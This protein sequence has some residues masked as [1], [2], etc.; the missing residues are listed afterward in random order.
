MLHYLVGSFVFFNMKVVELIHLCS[1]DLREKVW[2]MD[3]AGISLVSNPSTSFA[4]TLM[5]HVEICNNWL[6]RLCI[7]VDGR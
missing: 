5:Y 3:D 4:N 6:E 2:A 7:S 1:N